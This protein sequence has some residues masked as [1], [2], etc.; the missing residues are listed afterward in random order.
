M[1]TC[2]SLITSQVSSS[3]SKHYSLRDL[4]N[5][6]ID[7]DSDYSQLL[8]RHKGVSQS[9]SRKWNENFDYKPMANRSFDT[10][11]K[12]MNNQNN[13]QKYCSRLSDIRELYN[14]YKSKNSTDA[15]IN[16]NI[17]VKEQPNN[18]EDTFDNKIDNSELNQVPPLN[19][20]KIV[21]IEIKQVSEDMKSSDKVKLDSLKCKLCL[22]LST[23]L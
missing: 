19:E 22:L 11:F 1:D 7:K 13:S 4:S 18:F 9:N 2:Q 14:K 8:Y 23:R 10:K 16:L 5:T 17:S 15:K 12:T 6:Q 3:A 20:P 21:S